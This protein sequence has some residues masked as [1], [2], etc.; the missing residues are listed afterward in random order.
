MKKCPDLIKGAGQVDDEPLRLS[1]SIHQRHSQFPPPGPLIH[2][3]WVRPVLMVTSVVA[4]D[5]PGRDKRYLPGV[6]VIWYIPF[7]SVIEEPPGPDVASMG[8]AAT[9]AP[10]T[11][12]ESQSSVSQ[13]ATIHPQTPWVMVGVD[14]SS[15]QPSAK[16]ARAMVVHV[17]SKMDVFMQTT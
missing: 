5:T 10:S 4:T 17:A 14:D 16:Q 13:P 6:S 2:V 11:R 1:K 15:E 3:H 12:L 8:A 7:S 9:V